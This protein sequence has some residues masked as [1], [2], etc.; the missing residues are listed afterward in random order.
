LN[1]QAPITAPAVR[2]TVPMS[3]VGFVDTG[4]GMAL[5]PKDLAET[6]KFAEL[7]SRSGV[8]VPKHLRENPGA[9]M[10]VILQSLHWQ[11]DP[12][13]VANKSYSVNDRLAYEAQ[14]ITAVVNTRAPIQ[15]RLKYAFAGEGAALRCTV[16]GVVDGEE[17]IYQ[18]PPVGQIAVKNSPLWKSDPEQQLSYYSGRAWARRHT[19]EVILGVYS[20]D[21]AEEVKDVT[22][23]QGTGLKDRLAANQQDAQTGGFDPK[24]VSAEIGD[25]AETTIEQQV[26]ESD[27]EIER[28]G[29]QAAIDGEQRKAPEDLTPA[30]M[31]SWLKGYDAVSESAQ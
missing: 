26:E 8:A 25:Q 4:S 21:E 6:V 22:P 17:L 31:V 12:F 9:C 1:A 28:A 27:P 23:E 11:Y 30:Q 16:T 19:P 20:R 24:T 29:A 15:G 18:S 10:A 5:M 13:Q 3:A 2:E 7:M 14:L